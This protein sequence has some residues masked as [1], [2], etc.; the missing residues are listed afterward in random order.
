VSEGGRSEGMEGGKWREERRRRDG[1][2]KGRKV[3]INE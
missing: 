3:C 2:K 1:K